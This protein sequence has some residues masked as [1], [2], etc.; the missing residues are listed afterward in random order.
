[1]IAINDWHEAVKRIEKGKRVLVRGYGREEFEEA[2]KLR[3]SEHGAFWA[4]TPGMRDDTWLHVT[5]LKW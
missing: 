3:I 2:V 1:M 5:E 4:K